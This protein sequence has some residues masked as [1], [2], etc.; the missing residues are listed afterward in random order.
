MLPRRTPIGPRRA[1]ARIGSESLAASAIHTVGYRVVTG[2]VAAIVHPWLG[3][4]LLRTAW[5]NLHL[6]WAVA[7]IATGRLTPLL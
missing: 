7:L 4:R 1:R 6:L 3:P 5:I 2:I